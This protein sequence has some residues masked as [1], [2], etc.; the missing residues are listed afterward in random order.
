MARFSLGE[1]L[2][3][4]AT[5][6]VYRAHDTVSGETVALKTPPEEVALTEWARFAA[7]YEAEAV[8]LRTLSH[9]TLLAIRDQG[10]DE[11][12]PFIAYEYLQGPSLRSLFGAGQTYHPSQVAA[13]LAPLLEGTD[14][15]H[16]QGIVHR[17]INPNNLV[18][19]L[20]ATPYL[21]LIDF[22]AAARIGAPPGPLVGTPQYM[23][24][25][26]LAG[27]APDPR[28]DLFSVGV[29]AYEMLTGR[30]PF[31]GTS[32]PEIV[33]VI[34]AGNFQRA[35][36]LVPAIPPS[37]DSFLTTA[38]AVDP[39]RRFQAALAMRSV[40][41]R[42]MAGNE[43]VASAQAIA[44][45]Q[46]IDMTARPTMIS[47]TPVV[48]AGAVLIASAGPYSG[49]QFPLSGGITTLGGAY[50]D[51][52]LSRDLAIAAQHCWIVDENGQ[53]LLCDA[54]DSGGTQL[55]SQWVKRAPLLTGDLITIGEST[56][57]FQDPH[58]P[59]GANRPAGSVQYGSPPA[60][61]KTH[62]RYADGVSAS[63]HGEG[64][65]YTPAGGG[66][67]GGGTAIMLVVFVLFL[68]G[69]V[70]L[71]ALTYPGIIRKAMDD[72]LA[73]TWAE[74]E[75][76][77]RS[78]DEAH[79]V[80]G[81]RDFTPQVHADYLPELSP[82]YPSFLAWLPPIAQ[83]RDE[84]L[85][86]KEL[87]SIVVDTL[88]GAQSA[89]PPTGDNTFPIAAQSVLLNSASSVEVLR[90]TQGVWKLR[91]QYA[92]AAF[93]KFGTAPVTVAPE[94]DHP[95][96]LGLKDFKEG[97]KAYNTS[98]YDRAFNFTDQALVRVDRWFRNAPSEELD[99]P[100]G[101]KFP[102][103]KEA[104]QVLMALCELRESQIR[105]LHPAQAAPY[106]AKFLDTVQRDWLR[107]ARKLLQRVPSDKLASILL[108][109]DAGLPPETTHESLSI[110]M[111]A[112]DDAIDQ[113][114][115]AGATTQSSGE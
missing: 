4:G 61:A 14:Y 81:L 28:S 48:I 41:I 107:D 59:V 90:L 37:V 56:F 49:Q 35:S 82:E 77:L 6:T 53:Y 79:L 50:A 71:A 68:A 85:A 21:K 67:S 16:Q 13:L 84:A 9:P 44:G 102:S 111:D 18:M 29:V 62:Q 42:A 113:Q 32:F 110:E 70:G 83:A 73:Q 40:L 39:G 91:K 65:T 7:A 92:V 86:S 38:L 58:Q 8:V 109:F 46:A 100:I 60:R 105:I 2:G 76:I 97:M 31:V 98:D 45:A 57:R 23:A 106:D 1:M 78:T 52:N 43:E 99:Q 3:R 93:T 89:L 112:V 25:E 74:V 19:V 36:H 103:G 10:L 63:A 24:P 88:A 55:N 34:R 30:P 96:M 101:D 114:R 87:V 15:L 22:G 33:Q 94:P 20:E 47:G 12:R 108:A 104:A 95:F 11:G 5:G 115:N 75:P 26:Q 54:D 80:T 72:D 51:I 27:G 17:D 64:A 66:R 69:L